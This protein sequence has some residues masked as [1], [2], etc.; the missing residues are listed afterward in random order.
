MEKEES[1]SQKAAMFCKEHS[2]GRDNLLGPTSWEYALAM[3]D[4]QGLEHHLC[5]YGTSLCL[6]NSAEEERESL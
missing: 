4:Q 1:S 3:A 2:V 6:L 5:W